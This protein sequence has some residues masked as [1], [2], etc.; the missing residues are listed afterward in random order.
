MPYVNQQS[1]D[2]FDPLTRAVEEAIAIEGA[3]SGELNYIFTRLAIAYAKG[4]GLSYTTYNE[5]DGVFGEAA[6][7]FYRRV[8]ALYEDKK[9]AANGDVYQDLL[10]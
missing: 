8:T 4:R 3:T 2:R 7:E 5:I 10:R 9:I 1:R 6:K